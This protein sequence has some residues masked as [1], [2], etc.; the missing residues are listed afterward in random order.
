MRT[1]L[2]HRFIVGAGRLL[3]TLF[4]LALVAGALAIGLMVATAVLLRLAWRRSRG[5]TAPS[6]FA[7]RRPEHAG[8]VIDAEVREVGVREVRYT[9]SN[10]PAA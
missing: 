9:A 5:A 10:R 6:S 3:R 2:L 1:P 7:R 4:A 8:D